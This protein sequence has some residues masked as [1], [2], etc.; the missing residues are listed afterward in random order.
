[1]RYRNNFFLKLRGFLSLQKNSMVHFYI[2]Q[3]A[4]KRLERMISGA[5]NALKYNFN[6]ALQ[7]KKFVLIQRSL[8]L[9]CNFKLLSYGSRYMCYRRLYAKKAN[10]HYKFCLFKKVFF[11]FKRNTI[12]TTE[13]DI[14]INNERN[15]RSQTGNKNSN[16]KH[17]PS[18]EV[19]FNTFKIPLNLYLL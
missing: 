11:G 18:D 19:R 17:S 16:L 15:M 8:A 13:E 14:H 1:M 10:K 3:A 6:L 12:K 7:K 9:I 4:H 5:F 2:K